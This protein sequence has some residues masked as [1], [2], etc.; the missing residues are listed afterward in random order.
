MTDHDARSIVPIC[1]PKMVAELVGMPRSTVYAWM[2]PT[3]TRPVLVH[4]VPPEVRGHPSIPLFGLAEASVIRGMRQAKMRMSEIAA[5]VE[6]IRDQHGE[7]ALASPGLVTDGVSALIEQGGEV[8]TLRGGQGVFRLIIEERL[9][10]FVLAPDGFVE[11]YKIERL[12][13][14]EMD[15]RFSSGRMRFTSTGVPVFAVRGQ[16]SAGMPAEVVAYEFGLEIDKVRA[17]EELERTDPDW[18]SEV[19]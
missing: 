4:S 18:L 12:P 9:H 1:T 5:A 17:I 15:P 6:Y 2:R 3:T 14:V 8:S 16:L 10:P 13:D 11:S 19:A 7:Y